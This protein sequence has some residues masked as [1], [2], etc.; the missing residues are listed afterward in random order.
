MANQGVLGLAQAI[1]DVAAEHADP[2]LHQ[3]GVVDVISE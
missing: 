3:V 2:A 1:V